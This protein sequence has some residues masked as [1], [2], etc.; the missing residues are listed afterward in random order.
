MV[1]ISHSDGINPF[2]SICDKEK[3]VKDPCYCA[4]FAI[5]LEI[6]DGQAKVRRSEQNDGLFII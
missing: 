1:I 6:I 4:T 2:L 3:K 5:E